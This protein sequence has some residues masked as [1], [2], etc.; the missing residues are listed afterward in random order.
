MTGSRGR[1]LLQSDDMKVL[2]ISVRG[3]HLGY[4]SCYGNGWIETPMLDSLAAESVVFDQHYA[5]CPDPG[6][7]RRSWRSGCSQLPRLDGQLPLATADYPDL[8]ESLRQAGI[9]THLVADGSRPIPDAFKDGWDAVTVV[10]PRRAES[11]LEQ[12]LSTTVHVLE[13]LVEK[14]HWLVWVDLATLVP[15]WDVPEEYYAPYFESDA[16]GDDENESEEEAEE[17]LQPLFDPQPG[18]I[19][20][21]DDEMLDR[22]QY[23]YAGAVTFLDA[24]LDA[25]VEELGN[26]GLGD[27]IVFML[28]SDHGL[29]L[30]EHGMMG[31]FRPWLHEELS[32]IPLLLSLPDSQNAGRR[33]PALTQPSDLMPTLLDLFGQPVPST[34]QGR[35]LLP[36]ARG[37]TDQV[38][39]HVCSGLQGEGGAEY[40]L[41]TSEWCF[42]LPVLVPDGDPPRIAQLYAKP[43]DRWEVNNVIHHHQE[44]AEE[45]ER[46][47]RASITS[48]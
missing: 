22:L 46:T 19:A 47:L 45:L 8:L 6:A 1:P 16:I 3:L 44:V 28:T 34:V 18:L 12:T 2:V 32:H 37:E 41:R 7:A 10:K 25:L 26:L 30:G 23:S 42:I 40:A 29:P 11:P 17:P 4:L 24:A 27:E 43:E 15:P 31:L 48:S 14:E 9:A 36:L 39:P 20:K 13:R 33:V 35:S 21:D 5:D 38:R